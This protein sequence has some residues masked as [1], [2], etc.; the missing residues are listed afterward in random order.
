M[1]R[2]RN[3]ACA[4]RLTGSS[5]CS[6]SLS[7]GCS[8]YPLKE[9][10]VS[11]ESAAVVKN[12]LV[13]ELPRL[14]Q[15]RTPYFELTDEMVEKA[16]SERAETISAFQGELQTVRLTRKKDVRVKMAVSC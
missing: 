1:R 14:V 11:D 12:L 13:K 10:E 2:R 15:A 5:R 9:G 16:F 3:D 6:T 7:F 8:P 4:L